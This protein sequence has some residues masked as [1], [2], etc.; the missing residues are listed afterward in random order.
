MNEKAH[1]QQRLLS[2]AIDLLIQLTETPDDAQILT[3][4]ENW[5]I[6]T[7]RHEAIWQ[8]LDTA[9]GAAGFLLEA[10]RREERRRAILSRRSVILGGMAMMGTGG[11]FY[12]PGHDALI[13]LRAD[14]FTRK[15]VIREV[16][17][18]DR[19]SATLGPKSALDVHGDGAQ[20]IE[21]LAFFRV[22]RADGPVTIT[23]ETVSLSLIWG[24][25]D[26][27]NEAGQTT[28]TLSEGSATVRRMYQ[29]GPVITLS[30]GEWASFMHNGQD[31]RGERGRDDIASWRRNE[32]VVRREPASR[33]ISRIGRWHPARIIFA[34]PGVGS[35]RV[36]G[37]FDLSEP[38]RALAAVV[39]SAG[40]KV[41][42]LSDGLLVIS[43]V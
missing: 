16:V 10:R 22:A 29:D 2:E 41:R 14:Y 36:S 11:F 21:G 23:D 25:F 42:R 12:G 28:V 1:E 9:H 43:A 26:I 31:Q 20:L 6:L 18:S 38:E 39:D 19:I 27:W 24:S 3:R 4:I 34:A 5:R 40:G 35:V 15:G 17:L 33:V 37:L 8:Q 32:L 7:P 13:R 30:A